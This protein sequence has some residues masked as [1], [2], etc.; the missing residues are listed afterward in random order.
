M[1][2]L[3][4]VVLDG[5]CTN[6]IDSIEDLRSWQGDILYNHQ[7]HGNGSLE[8]I[9][10]SC[11]DDLYKIQARFHQFHPRWFFRRSPGQPGADASAHPLTIAN[12]TSNQI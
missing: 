11:R 8:G 1:L 7:E 5:S 9:C 2:R 6:G 10:H 4:D 12:Q 3:L